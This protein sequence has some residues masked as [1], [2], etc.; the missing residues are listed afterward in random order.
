MGTTLG[1]MLK[2]KKNVLWEAL[3][4]TI[5]I[6]L[7][8]LF[9]GMLLE[10]SN[11]TKISNLFTRSEISLT[12]ATTASK[13]TEDFDFDCEV[14]KKNNI[15]FADRIYE[16]AKELEKYEESGKLTDSMKILHKKYDLMRTILWVSNQKAL[17][18]CKNYGLIVY[19]Y[20]YNS[21]DTNK[22]ATQNVWSKILLDVKQQN[23]NVLLLPIA[24]DQNLISLDL[25]KSE[26]GIKEFPAL[27]INN[28]NIVYDVQNIEQIQALLN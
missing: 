2:S 14:I 4:I 15:D 5:V 27:V 25:L 9:L 3:I 18:K 26:Y 1:K 13:L 19:L 10:T 21:E 22:K 16:E 7:V 17:D 23:E 8:G 6:F 12:D 24:A 28:E 11:S 20:E